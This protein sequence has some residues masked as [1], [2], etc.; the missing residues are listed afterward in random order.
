MTVETFCSS[1]KAERVKGGVHAASGAILGLM[2]LYNGVAWCYRRERHLGWNTIL[3]TVG[4]AFEMR[5]THR[6]L[7]RRCEPARITPFDA[8]KRAD[9]ITARIPRDAELCGTY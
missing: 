8:S 7:V 2:A 3:Y 6:H 4:F 5:Q 9:G 1:G